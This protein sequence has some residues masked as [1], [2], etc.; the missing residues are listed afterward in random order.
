MCNLKRNDKNE[1]AYKTETNKD[2]ENELMVMGVG[3]Q[4]IVREF[5]MGL[6]TVL[7][8]KWITNKD[9]LYS[10][11]NSAQHYVAAWMGGKSRGEWIHVY[12]WLSLLIIHLNISQN[13]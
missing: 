11:W 12:V 7:Y 5:G 9:L 6:Y 13:C 1:V 10:K 8:F 3:G 4:R 2:C